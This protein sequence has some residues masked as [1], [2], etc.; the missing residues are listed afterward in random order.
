MAMHELDKG[1]ATLEKIMRHAW[2]MLSEKD[3]TALARAYAFALIRRIADKGM[4]KP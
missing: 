1:I 3:Q 4:E 2:D